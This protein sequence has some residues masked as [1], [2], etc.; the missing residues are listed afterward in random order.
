MEFAI[1]YDLQL[2]NMVKQIDTPKLGLEYFS[3]AFYG[4]KSYL[5]NKV[6]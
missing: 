1:Y 6:A 4:L 3:L 2:F 5:M